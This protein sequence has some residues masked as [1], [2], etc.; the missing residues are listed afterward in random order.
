MATLSPPW[1]DVR[2]AYVR[3]TLAADKGVSGLAFG[4][5]LPPATGFGTPETTYSK[6]F[7]SLEGIIPYMTF[8]TPG[9]LFRHWDYPPPK[10]ITR[11]TAK[12]AKFTRASHVLDIVL[13]QGLFCQKN[14][15]MFILKTILILWAENFHSFRRTADPPHVR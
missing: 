15:I 13:S 2:F 3:L 7:V 1:M 14:W 12:L 11:S 5:E 4:I 6:L 8:S 10:V 9:D